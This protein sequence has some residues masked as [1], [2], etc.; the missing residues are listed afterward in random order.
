MALSLLG[1]TAKLVYVTD[2]V[3]CGLAVYQSGCVVVWKIAG[4]FSVGSAWSAKTLGTGL[5]PSLL[6]A[7]VA[8]AIQGQANQGAVAFVDSYGR[9]I[10]ESKANDLSS[11]IWIFA[12]GAY[13][14][15]QSLG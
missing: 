12:S 2:T 13:I 7:R 10:A 14:T 6:Q 11:S 1:G 3:G 9:L 4:C 5:P 15:D 8:L